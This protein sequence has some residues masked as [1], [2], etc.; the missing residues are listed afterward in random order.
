MTVIITNFKGFFILALCLISWLAASPAL[1]QTYMDAYRAYN[2][3]LEAGDN[4]AAAEHG[5]AAWQAAE[6]ELG[7][8]GLTAILAYNYGQLVLF[9]D[10]ENAAKALRRA[11]AL[12]AEG[13]ADLPA[14]ELKLSLAFT[15]F[16]VSGEKRRQ[17]R[18]LRNALN[19]TEADGM[20]ASSRS[21]IIWL[22]LARGD[23]TKSR[24]E[25]AIES[26]QRAEEIISTAIPDDYRRKAQAILIGGIAH[27]SPLPRSIKDVQMAHDEFIR[28][29]RLFPPQKNLDNFDPILAQLLAW[30]AGADAALYSLRQKE[31]HN[32]KTKSRDEK[33]AEPIQIFEERKKSFDECNIEWAKR[34]K[35]K[36]SE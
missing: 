35:T 16:D 24:Y 11:E 34:K 7:D 1:A 6:A 31:Y 19:A 3:A 30:N 15:E 8:D 14:S 18:I 12:R 21:A 32:H 33:A 9:S 5:Y 29:I 22:R 20:A 25:K 13:V 28:A 2:A 26:A 27:L 36:I 23:L 17:S 4:A 10:A